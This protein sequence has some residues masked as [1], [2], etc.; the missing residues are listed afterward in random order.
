MSKA[1]STTVAIIDLSV[2]PAVAANYRPPSLGSYPDTSR[3]SPRLRR[4]ARLVAVV[5]VK[6]RHRGRVLR[7][8]LPAYVQIVSALTTS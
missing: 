5:R 3:R 7:G 4:P 1:F 6:P 8:C 2:C